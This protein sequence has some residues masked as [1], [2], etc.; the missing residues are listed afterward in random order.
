MISENKHSPGAGPVTQN[1]AA[2]TKENTL[3]AKLLQETRIYIGTKCKRKFRDKFMWAFTFK[4]SDKKDKYDMRDLIDR[5]AVCILPCRKASVKYVAIIAV[6]FLGLAYR[7]E[8]IIEMLRDDPQNVKYV[9]VITLEHDNT[10]YAFEL[11][12]NDVSDIIK[13]AYREFDKKAPIPN[14]NDDAYFE[15]I[16]ST[17]PKSRK[18]ETAADRACKELIKIYGQEKADKLLFR[19]CKALTSLQDG[20]AKTTK[21]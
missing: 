14:L 6:D 8:T 2:M 3:S 7:G 16:L 1:T 12:K 9:Y 15:Y 18:K 10:A 4:S 19:M 13:E 5:N 11:P 17:I 20:Q 21:E